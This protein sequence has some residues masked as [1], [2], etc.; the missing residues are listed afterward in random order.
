MIWDLLQQFW[1]PL[2]G[3]LAAVV[4]GLGVYLKGRADAAHGAARR[5]LQDYRDTR[6]RMDNAQAPGSVDA[7]R[8]WLRDR[9][10][11]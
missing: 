10:Q 5:D 2:A 1:A 11:R 9:A 6:E 7:A 8:G 3:L 4:A